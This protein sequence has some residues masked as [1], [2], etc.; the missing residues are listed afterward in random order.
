MPSKSEKQKRFMQ[1][2]AHNPKFAEKAGISQSVAKEF[3]RA[4]QRAVKLPL[5]TKKRR[6]RK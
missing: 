3:F 6:W 2:A 4:D 1:A 5:S